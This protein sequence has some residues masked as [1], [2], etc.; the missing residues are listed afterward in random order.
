MEKEISIEELYSQPFSITRH[1]MIPY[2]DLEVIISPTGEIEY[3]L[4]SHQE[5]LITRKVTTKQAAALRK[6]KLAGL[7]TGKIPKT[8]G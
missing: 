7:Y 2:L 3:A 6:L 1:K 5:C 4:P 8:K